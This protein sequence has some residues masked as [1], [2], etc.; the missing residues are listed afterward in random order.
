MP[1]FKFKLEGVFRQRK[2][3]E[4]ERQRE[5]AASRQQAR[6]LEEELRALNQSLQGTVEDV[7]H[8][9]LTGRLDL[10]FLAAHRRY[11]AAMQRKG[12]ALVQRLANLSRQIETQQRALA[13]AAKQR[14]AIEKLR[15]RRW[16]QW[17]AEQ[18]K[19][20]LAQMDEI[21]QQMVFSQGAP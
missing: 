10:S 12:D 16:E 19:R 6:L 3:L 8:N 11:A 2:Q 17:L 9:R 7:R 4:R 1:R 14:K 5:V 21:A 18:S 13:E 20:E 15:E